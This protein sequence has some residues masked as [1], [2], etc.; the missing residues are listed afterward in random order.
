MPINECVEDGLFQHRRVADPELQNRTLKTG[1]TE[2]TRSVTLSSPTLGLVGKLD[3]L[4]SQGGESF[5]VEY[6]RSSGPSY[7]FNVYRPFSSVEP[8]D[9]RPGFESP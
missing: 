6:K 1:G 9:P 3:V 5:P 8:V 2:T 7:V 4:E